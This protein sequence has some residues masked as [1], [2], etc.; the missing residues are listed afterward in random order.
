MIKY[1]KNIIKS[2]KNRYKRILEN[3]Q[4]VKEIK[5]EIN[6]KK[7]LA[8]GVNNGNNEYFQKRID[9]E[10]FNGYVC[11]VKIKN[12]EKPWLISND[13]FNVCILDENYE[14]LEIYPDNEKYA[15]TVMYDD[16]QNLIEWYFDMIKSRGIENGI[17]YIDD[18]YLDLVIGP[19]GEKV[20]LDEDELKNALDRNEIT[21]EE[22]EMAYMTLRKLE[23]KYVENQEELIELTTKLFK[24]IKNAY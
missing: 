22:F 13:G 19:K 17:P 11:L 21:L 14:W 9:N 15:I 2:V 1:T 7:R 4:K 12:V 3:K 6:M 18:L 24:E 20:V 23:N 8:D 10:Y 16:K 5:G